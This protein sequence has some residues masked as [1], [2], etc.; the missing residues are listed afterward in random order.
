MSFIIQTVL[1]AI[2]PQGIYTLVTSII[3]MVMAIGWN[4]AYFVIFYLIIKKDLKYLNWE[5]IH[6]ISS[7][8]IYIFSCILSFNIFRLFYS[9]FLG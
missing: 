1:A 7:K 9:R 6:T 2:H 3:G 8:L 5:K 4:I